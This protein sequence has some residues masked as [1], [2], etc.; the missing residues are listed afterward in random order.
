MKGAEP[1]EPREMWAGSEMSGMGKG[2]GPG[3]A[4]LGT[5]KRWL[6]EKAGLG[7]SRNLRLG[8]SLRGRGNGRG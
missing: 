7:K 3:G 2:L 8:R 1:M 5:V 4:G 6:R